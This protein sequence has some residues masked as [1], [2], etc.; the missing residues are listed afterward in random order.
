MKL[1]EWFCPKCGNKVGVGVALTQPPI[2]SNHMNNKPI[3]MRQKDEQRKPNP[4][5]D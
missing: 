2:C 3:E 4:R 5:V 1:F